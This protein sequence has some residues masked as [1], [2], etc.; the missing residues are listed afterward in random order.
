MFKGQFMA[1]LLLALTTLFWAGN[2]VLARMFHLDIPPVTMATLR[3]SLA[4]LLIAPFVIPKIIAQWSVIRQHYKILLALSIIGVASFNT[5]IYCGLQL[6]TATNGTLLQ[7]A[8]PIMIL[9]LSATVL[10]ENISKRQ[11]TG[12]G[13]STLGVLLLISKGDLSNLLAL[14]INDGDL[15]IL[16]AVLCWAVYSILLRWRP[17]QIDGFTLFGITVSVTVVVLWPLALL[18]L[19]TA[20][21]IQFSISS[22][23]TIGYMAIF[24]S[25]LAYLFWNRG[26]AELGAAKAGLFIH[27][28]PMYGIILSATFLNERVEY[29]HLLGILLIFS[30]IYLAVMTK[31]FMRTLLRQ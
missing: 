17:Q 6:T 2:F 3:W 5:L 1:Y 8:I 10:R 21:A 24:P 13:I 23:A 19:Q 28:M 7:S 9:I 18:E 31:G 30:G 29:F 27:L 14:Q 11:W 4:W 15:W 26:I 12:V 16:A 22:A 25:I 20:P